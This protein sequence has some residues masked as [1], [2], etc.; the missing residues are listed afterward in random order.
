M[1]DGAARVRLFAQL[2]DSPLLYELADAT[3]TSHDQMPELL[4]AVADGYAEQV[5]HLPGLPP[6]P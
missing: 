4:R 6:P 5:P 1:S 3:I 2:G